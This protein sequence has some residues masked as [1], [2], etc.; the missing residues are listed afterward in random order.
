MN[1]LYCLSYMSN[2]EENRTELSY[3]HSID[4]LCKSVPNTRWNIID[5]PNSKTL[6]RTSE[7]GEYP[8]YMIHEVNFII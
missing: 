3:S 4:K 7:K 2:E 6:K 8:F 1:K 5:D